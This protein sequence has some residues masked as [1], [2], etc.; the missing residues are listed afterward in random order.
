MGPAEFPFSNIL[1]EICKQEGKKYNSGCFGE[2]GGARVQIG[3]KAAFAAL[4]LL[5]FC[6]KSSFNLI[7]MCY[8]LNSDFPPHNPLSHR[9]PLFPCRSQRLPS[10]SLNPRISHTLLL[11]V[12]FF[13][14]GDIESPPK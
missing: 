13:I 8:K 14:G 7:S 11:R 1:N 9:S 6:H 3:K 12:D 10:L 5:L 2:G 4:F